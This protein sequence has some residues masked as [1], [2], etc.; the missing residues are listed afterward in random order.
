MGDLLRL[1]HARKSLRKVLL[2]G[3]AG[4]A[5]ADFDCESKPTGSLGEAQAEPVNSL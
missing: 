1:P 4:E 2:I 5:R 3:W